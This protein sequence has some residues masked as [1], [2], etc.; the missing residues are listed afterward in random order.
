MEFR[1]QF[2]NHKE[3]IIDATYPSV[4]AIEAAQSLKLQGDRTC[5]VSEP[6]GYVTHWR[7]SLLEHWYARPLEPG[8]RLS[9]PTK[10]EKAPRGW[11]CSRDAGHGGPC[12]AHP[13][14]S[15]RATQVPR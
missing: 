5:A 15:D 2:E 1:V 10:C 6:G 14:P 11:S 9:S 12:A 7:V 4:A 13:V 3:V 8:K